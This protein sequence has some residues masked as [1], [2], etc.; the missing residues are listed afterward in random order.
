MRVQ[1]VVGDEER[2]VGTAGWHQQHA[3]AS[4]VRGLLS[5]PDAVEPAFRGL[6][7]AVGVF[8]AQ[9]HEYRQGDEEQ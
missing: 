6:A 1:A 5:W 9:Q 4:T 8:A 2:R 3:P 7:A